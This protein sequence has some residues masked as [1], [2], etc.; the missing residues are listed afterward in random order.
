VAVYKGNG[1]QVSTYDGRPT[2]SG[3]QYAVHTEAV[4]PGARYIS[5]GLPA[6]AAPMGTAAASA[7]TSVG[8]AATGNV[9]L[10][11]PNSPAAQQALA[12]QN[13]DAKDLATSL[14]NVTV[15]AGQ[16]DK[17]FAGM[18]PPEIAAANAELLR[19]Q[20]ILEKN[21]LA[22]GG[23]NGTAAVSEADKQLAVNAAWGQSLEYEAAYAKLLTDTI[24]HTGD[25]AADTQHVADIVGGPMADAY[26]KAA[27]ASAQMA[28]AQVTITQLT[29]AHTQVVAQRAAAD[30]AS[31]RA[32]TEAGW[33]QQD[34]TAAMQQRQQAASNA[35]AD[36]S[37][38]ENDRYTQ[39][40]RDEQDRQRQLQFSQ[41]VQAT[42][43]QNKLTDLQ[44]SQTQ[45]GYNRTSS[46]QVQAAA[47]GGASTNQAAGAAAATLSVMHNQD[48]AQKDLNTKAID[49]IQLQIREQAKAANLE[50]Y[51]LQTET[52]QQ[53]RQHENIM[54]GLS[55]QLQDQ[56]QAEDATYTAAIAA[57]NTIK[58]SAQSALD[59]ANQ[60]LSVFSATGVV[61][62]GIA[63]SVGA[64]AASA[65]NNYAANPTYTRTLGTHAAGGII[66][67]T[68]GA[69]L[70]GERGPEIIHAPGMAVV[71]ATQTAAMMGGMT[72]NLNLGDVGLML[73]DADKRDIKAYITAKLDAARKAGVNK[74]TALGIRPSMN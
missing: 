21:A 12:Q 62:D 53:Q 29:A 16:V 45:Q 22:H 57:Q 39:V 35:L 67:L 26:G 66:P 56:R 46:E 49:D 5:V 28:A 32:A 34:A 1:Q 65:Q 43:L 40:Q 71:P 50:S 11:N 69:S 7:I 74:S 61:I 64:S 72:V 73:S 59:L 25:L 19:M 42:D 10:S 47:V 8:N 15:A 38:A 31:S 58:T 30:Q 4:N 33:A 60:A 18:N 36:R 17:A 9:D 55:A 70:V 14:K 54:A 3:D 48:L 2:P 24:N 41:Q 44:K 51:N 63:Q 52:I 27:A 6:A 20:P 37:T 68:E 23:P 13:Q